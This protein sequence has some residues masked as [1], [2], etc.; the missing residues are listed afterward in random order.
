MQFWQR[1]LEAIQAE[2]I[3]AVEY[4][5]REGLPVRTL[6]NRR[7]TLNNRLAAGRARVAQHPSPGSQGNTSFVA[8]QLPAQKFRPLQPPAVSTAHIGALPFSYRIRFQSGL[9]IEL[10]QLPDVNWLLDLARKLPVA[11]GDA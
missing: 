3:T 1:H 8:V 6:Y 11:T 9:S 2:G 4:A 5:A 7:K 10:A